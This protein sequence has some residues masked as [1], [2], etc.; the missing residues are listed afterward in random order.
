MFKIRRESQMNKNKPLPE[1]TELDYYECYAKIALESL[2]PEQFDLD[3]KDKPDLQDSIKK[4]GVEVT[5]GRNPKQQEI[6]SLYTKLKYNKESSP[7]KLK[8]QIEKCGGKLNGGILSGISERDDFG[9][10]V[11]A[12]KR[13]VDKINKGEYL[14]M[15]SYDLFIFDDCLDMICD[16]SIIK[17]VSSQMQKYQKNKMVQYQYVYICTPSILWHL[18]LQTGERKGYDISK[19]QFGWAMKACEMVEE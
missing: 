1:H 16:Q 17:S 13:K 11:Q 19:Q 8:R 3:I 14:V 10:A 9:Y 12:F 15:R 6:E 5:L 2:F 7:E 4:I 18:S